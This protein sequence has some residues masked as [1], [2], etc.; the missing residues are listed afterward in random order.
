VGQVRRRDARG[1]PTATGGG[2]RPGLVGPWEF[3]AA[4]PPYVTRHACAT[5]HPVPAP[6]S[7]RR[8]QRARHP[9]P[10][11]PRQET[12]ARVIRLGCIR[13]P[14]DLRLSPHCGVP[15]IMVRPHT[16]GRAPVTGSPGR[17]PPTALPTEDRP[18]ARA[19]PA[20]TLEAQRRIGARCIAAL[21]RSPHPGYTISTRV[22]QN[23]NRAFPS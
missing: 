13:A 23:R 9:K 14:R 17:T 1:E 4:A 16:Q 5:V 21:P 10:G 12:P 20:Q 8:S 15:R 7:R 2:A 6:R 18:L 22:N 11:I 19:W 3:H